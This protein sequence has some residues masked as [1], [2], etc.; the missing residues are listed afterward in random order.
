MTIFVHD[1]CPALL[2]R[3]P[4]EPVWVD[5]CT[6][7]KLSID[8]AIKLLILLCQHSWKIV[9]NPFVCIVATV[10]DKG[11]SGAPV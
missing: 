8:K 10:K 3:L 7:F 4:A 5:S 9:S 2:P 11:K 1:L 6:V